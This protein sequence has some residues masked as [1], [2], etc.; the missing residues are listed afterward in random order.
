MLDSLTDLDGLNVSA[1][2]F[3]AA[4]LETAAR[5]IWVVDPD[6]VIRFAN[7]A[8]IAALGYDRAED[9]FGC[10]SHETIHH[11]R[12]DGS[13]YPAAECPMRRSRMA[14]ETVASDLDWFVRRDGSMFR[15]SY[16]SVPI[17][18]PGGRGAVVAFGDIEDRLR[19]EQMR[20]DQDA[21]LQRQQ[22]ALRRV[23]MLV[24]GGAASP[25]VFAAIAREVAQVLDMALVVV[26][27]NEPDRPSTVAGAW[28]D[29]PHPFQEGSTWPVEEHTAAALLPEIG[30]P[31]RIEDFAAIG[32]VI[33][34]AIA[35]IGIRSGS[36]AAIV[37][38]GEFW[39]VMGAGVA[40]SEPL[41]D[42]IEDRLG[43]FTELVATAISNTE[44]RNELAASRARI[45]AATDDERRRVVRDLHDGA[46]QRLV[47]TIITL[48]LALRAS[49]DEERDLAG[50]L[51][52]ALRHA[53]QATA[54]L[55][56]LAHGILPAVLTRG[57]LRAGVDALASRMPLPVENGVAVGR[58]PDA[59]EATAFRRRR[60]AHQRRE[61]RSRRMRRGRGAR[62]GRQPPSRGARRRRR[63]GS[64]RR[65]ALGLADRLD[66]LGGKLRIES[67]AGGGT[68]V[69][70]DIPV[71]G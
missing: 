16:V 50:L 8:A 35:A 28:G 46:Q 26:W 44:A 38:D 37:V 12:A 3:L 11:R 27:R 23:A 20:R 65:G 15:V 39:G 6:D 10:R 61:A 66:V 64:A 29:R 71:C 69:A 59:V 60:G 56:E 43:E 9:L 18:M 21:A 32:G 54:E 1:E 13:P 4:V 40:E 55:R 70:A 47:H 34:D 67:P 58:L 45:V 36:G 53:E 33:P 17:E 5:P 25:D 62:R 41:P 2:D 14:G 57:G 52:E 42:H 19:A 48:K 7:P 63:R 68:L 24:A 30:R 51:T 31:A 49:G 22:A